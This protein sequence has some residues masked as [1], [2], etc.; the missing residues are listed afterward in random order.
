MEGKPRLALYVH[1]IGAS[2]AG[3]ALM[4]NNID[5]FHSFHRETT[6][7]CALMPNKKA[8]DGKC[9]RAGLLLSHGKPRNG[10]VAAVTKVF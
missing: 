8:K 9:Q 1:Q 7:K 6:Y 10:S 4:A 3:L 2:K 5:T